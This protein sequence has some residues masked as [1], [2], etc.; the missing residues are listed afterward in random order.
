M[1]LASWRFQ[2]HRDDG[3]TFWHLLDQPGAPCGQEWTAGESYGKPRH[4]HLPPYKYKS[5][6]AKVLCIDHSKNHSNNIKLTHSNV[7]TSNLR[8]QVFPASAWPAFFKALQASIAAG[9]PIYH[10]A[11]YTVLENKYQAIKGGWK[12]SLVYQVPIATASGCYTQSGSM[13][14]AQESTQPHGTSS[15][16]C[17]GS[18]SS[19]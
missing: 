12:V 10:Q 4:T 7:C 1:Q 6:V 3:L 15:P 19:C 18:K 14:M 17:L 13:L 16:S 11:T 2:Q 5:A 9:G 8:M